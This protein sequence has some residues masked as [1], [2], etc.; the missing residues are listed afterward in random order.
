ML[1]AF[2]YFIDGFIEIIH[3]SSEKGKKGSIAKIVYEK[4][5]LIETIIE[6]NLADLFFAEYDPK[7][8][9]NSMKVF[10]RKFPIQKVYFFQLSLCGNNFLSLL[11]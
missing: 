2:F 4:L 10:L 11:F 6:N 7:H 3:L 1:F 5:E 8:T 9:N